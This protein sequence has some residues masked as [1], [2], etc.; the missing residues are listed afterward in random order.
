[1]R[2]ILIVVIIMSSTNA[3]AMEFNDSTTLSELKQS[4]TDKDCN[5]ASNF[6]DFQR[7][8]RGLRNHSNVAMMQKRFIN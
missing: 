8:P 1:M 7:H 6:Q 5:L 4:C 2:I 3:I